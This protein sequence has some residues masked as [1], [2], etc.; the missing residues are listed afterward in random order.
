MTRQRTGWTLWALL[1][2]AAVFC[3]PSLNA[4]TSF[5]PALEAHGLYANNYTL[6]MAWE[7]RSPEIRTWI[8]GYHLAPRDG[9]DAF[10]VYVADGVVLAD[11]DLEDLGLETKPWSST[12]EAPA[13]SGI[14]AKAAPWAVGSVPGSV[15]AETRAVAEISKVPAPDVK[16]LR[17][18]DTAAFGP[19]PVRTGV[20]QPLLPTLYI[21]GDH[22]GWQPNAEGGWTI[23]ALIEA[24]GAQGLRLELESVALPDGAQVY[25]YNA[26]NP[27]EGFGPLELGVASE[28]YWTPTCFG[29]SVVLACVL[30]EDA[31]LDGVRIH[32]ARAAYLYRGVAE[33]AKAARVAGTCNLDVTCHPDWLETSHG[34][35]GIGTIGQAGS[36]F[37]TGAL[38]TDLDPCTQ[39]PFFLTANH[40]ITRDSAAETSEFYWFFQT[41][42]C[43]GTAPDPATVPRTIGGADRLAFSGGR[44][45]TGGGNDFCF[46]RLRNAPPASVTHL[47]WSTEVQA[48]GTSVTCVHHPR[49]EFKRI[50]FGGLTNST[51]LNPGSFH[52]VT[53]QQGTTEPG[54]SGSP[55]MRTDTHQII[56]QLWGGGASCTNPLDPDYY[57]RFDVTYPVI[58]SLLSEPLR[59]AF[60]ETALTATENEGTVAVTITLNKPAGPGGYQVACAVSGGT[61]GAGDL[62]LASGTLV[63][64]EGE[65]GLVFDITLIDDTHTEEEESTQLVLSSPSCGE[66]D[67]THGTLTLTILDDDLDSDGDGL[68]DADELSGFYGFI[69]NP[70]EPDSD[71]DGLSDYDEQLGIYGF[72]TSPVLRDSDGDGVTDFTEILLGLNPA[73][74]A[75]MDALPSMAVPWFREER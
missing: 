42:T 45:D 16:A 68:S 41:D 58:A 56:G 15:I 23:A 17:E 49:G 53:W 71:G 29:E 61:A 46:L 72:V 24:D 69:T 18:E 73:S 57:G 11:S 27:A 38:I 36:L 3:A 34:V 20:F 63:I 40:C 22:A 28:S 55:L 59:C 21:T 60:T 65:D 5:P 62:T 75:D 67:A 32:V 48:I 9:G 7:E 74:D 13:E 1:L 14:Q 31:L 4:E 39:M 30:P 43:N 44:P 2:A 51:L 66:I 70:G 10:D 52:E 54:S 33:L 35:G 50:T 19:K 6:L 64:P 26:A 25:I 8:H 12:R 37:C 47:G